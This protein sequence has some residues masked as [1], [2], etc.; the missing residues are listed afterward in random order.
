MC[1]VF[2][3]DAVGLFG[4]ARLPRWRGK[5]LFDVALFFTCFVDCC[6]LASSSGLGSC[7][8]GGLHVTVAVGIGVVPA[9]RSFVVVCT[10]WGVFFLWSEVCSGGCRLFLFSIQTASFC[11]AWVELQVAVFGTFSSGAQ[12]D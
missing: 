8:A 3:E 7:W 1:L 10:C 2:F 12:S 11:S 6:G 9:T 5:M 4:G